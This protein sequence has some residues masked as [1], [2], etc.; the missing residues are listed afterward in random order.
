[1]GNLKPKYY[2]TLAISANK[3]NVVPLQDITAEI[4]SF[5]IEQSEFVQFT[6]KL[7]TAFGF[8]QFPVSTL[9]LQGLHLHLRMQ[10]WRIQ[11]NPTPSAYWATQFETL[12]TV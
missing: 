4:S 7:S 8:L 1:L 9:I 3:S 6:T 5:Q 2:F 10:T 11:L 12:T